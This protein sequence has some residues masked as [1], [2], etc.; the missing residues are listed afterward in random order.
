MTFFYNSDVRLAMYVMFDLLCVMFDLLYV[1]V[2]ILLIC[3]NHLDDRYQVKSAPGH[4]GTYLHSQIG[5]YS[6]RH[7]VNSAPVLN[8]I[9]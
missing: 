2:G 1:R 9:L 8:I 6:N 3:G 4:F 7:L 5:T